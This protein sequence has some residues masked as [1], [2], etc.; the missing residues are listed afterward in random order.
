[1]GAPPPPSPVQGP[2]HYHQ[3][4]SRFGSKLP[5]LCWQLFAISM[6]SYIEY[7]V[8]YNFNDVV[9]GHDRLLVLRQQVRLERLIDCR[10]PL[11]DDARVG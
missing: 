10:R 5:N 11:P 7:I 1:M 6:T 2:C 3:R 9:Q 8:G 4:S